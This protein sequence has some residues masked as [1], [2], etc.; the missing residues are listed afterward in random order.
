MFVNIKV[1]FYF[2]PP[3]CYFWGNFQEDWMKLV[4][5]IPAIMAT[6]HVF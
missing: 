6:K 2:F 1:I 3:I 4:V 5:L